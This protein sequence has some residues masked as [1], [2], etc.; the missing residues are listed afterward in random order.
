ML[1]IHLHLE[2]YLW[3]LICLH[4][5]DSDICIFF[6]VAQPFKKLYVFYCLKHNICISTHWWNISYIRAAC[7]GRKTTTISPDDGCCTTETCSPDIIDISSM[8]WYTYVVF[9][10]VKYIYRIIQNDC[11]GV[12]NLSYTI[13][14]VLQ[15]QPHVISFYGVTSMIGFMLLFFPQVS[16]NWRLLRATNCWNELCYR[17]DV[18]RITKCAHIDH[19]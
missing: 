7:F 8:R 4:G 1:N 2:L 6:I 15:M 9:Y 17:V 18:C 12:N 10:T 11:R 16:R 14:L 19:P 5:V 3:Y 13:H